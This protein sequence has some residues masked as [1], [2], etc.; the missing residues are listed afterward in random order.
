MTKRPKPAGAATKSRKI[1]KITGERFRI[2]RQS[3]WLTLPQAAKVLQVTERTLHN[4]ES[5][6]CRVPFAAYKLIANSRTRSSS[7]GSGTEPC[8]RMA[9]WKAR[10]SNFSPS[11]FSASARNSRMRISPSL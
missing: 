7:T 8:R 10:M 6:A 5:G 3:C 4:W 11:A 9:S 2:A 1:N